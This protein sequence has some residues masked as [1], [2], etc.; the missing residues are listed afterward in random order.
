MVSSFKRII[1]LVLF[2]IGK[3]FK[4]SLSL[5][6]WWVNWFWNVTRFVSCLIFIPNAIIDRVCRRVLCRDCTFFS[7]YLFNFSF[8]VKFVPVSITT[9][10]SGWYKAYLFRA[11]DVFAAGLLVTKFFI[12]SLA[13]WSS[14]M[15]SASSVSMIFILVFSTFFFGLLF[16]LI[17]A[18]F[19]L[20]T[21]SFKSRSASSCTD[22]G[23]APCRGLE[24]NNKRTLSKKGLVST[25]DQ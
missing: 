24:L 21:H 19:M 13:I 20:F 6:F 23:T 12:K 17:G 10:V 16:N 7:F 9:M 3:R 4:L 11:F 2:I 25:N 8:N 18:S 1:S 15:S 14:G 5:C 22:A